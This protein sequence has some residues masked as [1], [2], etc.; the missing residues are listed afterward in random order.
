[1]PTWPTDLPCAPV[2]NSLQVEIEPNINEFKPDVGRPS[3]SM[4]YTR[5]RR[6]YSF[7]MSLTSAQ[8]A[9]LDDFFSN[10]DECAGGAKSFTMRDF[11]DH[12]LT[13]ATKTFTFNTPPSFRQVAPDRFAASISLT[14]EN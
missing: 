2:A 3:R 5:S 7:E 13:P 6:P 9:T 14:R 11:A 4:R 10:P 8:V 12:T 1:M